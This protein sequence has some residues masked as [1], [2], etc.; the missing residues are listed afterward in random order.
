MGPVLQ[1][2]YKTDL[3]TPERVPQRGAARFVLGDYIYNRDSSITAM[4]EN[5]G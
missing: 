1:Y 5:L 4:L 2:M 3:D